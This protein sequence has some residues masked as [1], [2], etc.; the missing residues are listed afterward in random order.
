M[1]NI[2]IRIFYS[3]AQHFGLKQ[4]HSHSL[5]FFFFLFKYKT[6]GS[7]ICF[8]LFQEWMFSAFHPFLINLQTD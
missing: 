1:R 5:F 3:A 7:A 4:K 6:Y 2:Y 8:P